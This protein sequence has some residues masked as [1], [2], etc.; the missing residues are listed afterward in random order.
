LA[1]LDTCLADERVFE[2]YLQRLNTL[3]GRPTVPVE[4]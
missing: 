1:A 4:T 2:P 3:I